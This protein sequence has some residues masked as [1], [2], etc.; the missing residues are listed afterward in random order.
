MAEFNLN[1]LRKLITEVK[2]ENSLLL[3]SPDDVKTDED[4]LRTLLRKAIKNTLD[5]DG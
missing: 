2:K 1:D 3:V 5:G 4:S